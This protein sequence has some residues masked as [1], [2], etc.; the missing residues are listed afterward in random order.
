M[1][2]SDFFSSYPAFDHDPTASLLGE[3]QRLSLQEG[4]NQKGKKYRQSRQKCLA[5]EFEDHY[6]H[7]S[8]KLDRWQELCADVGISPIPPSI[9][10]VK[11]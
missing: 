2:S 10:N 7:A 8:N 4:W 9:T 3:F 11:R 1:P 6:G 5:Q